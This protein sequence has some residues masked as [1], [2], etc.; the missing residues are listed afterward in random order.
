VTI[1]VLGGTA[2]LIGLLIAIPASRGSDPRGDGAVPEPDELR[3]QFRE[4]VKP[5][6]R[7]YCVSCHDE[8]AASRV[9]LDD[10]EADLTPATIDVWT[11]AKN[12]LDVGTM[13]PK[14]RTERPTREES[15]ALLAWIGA[16]LARYE[17]NHRE[18]GGDTLIRRVNNRAYARMLETL[19]GVPAQ[20][21]G[22]FPKDGEVRGYDT[23]G[24]GLYAT[25]SL[26]DLYLSCAQRTLDIAIPTA[27]AMP[28]AT[29]ATAVLR[30][31]GKA[32]EQVRASLAK[33][34]R[35]LRDDPRT[36]ATRDRCG[37]PFALGRLPVPAPLLRM[38][39]PNLVAEIVT[40][41]YRRPT[42]EA[43]VADG[44][45]WAADPACAAELLPAL[46]EQL[47]LLESFED[48]VSDLQPVSI[49]GNGTLK[50]GSLAPGYYRIRARLCL[51]DPAYPVP[52]CVSAGD[53]VVDQF[54]LYDPPSA[55]TV[56]E[57]TI[58]VGARLD[59]VEVRSPLPYAGDLTRRFGAVRYLVDHAKALYGLTDQRCEEMKLSNWIGANYFVSPTAPGTVA[60]PPA[61]IGI[62]CSEI[63]VS[64]PL[65]QAWPPP[66]ASRIFT[67]GPHAPPSREYAEEI[68]AAFMKRAYAV[69]G[70]DHDE[71]A[72]YVDLIMSHYQTG[73]DFVAAVK[74][75]LAG[76]LASPRFLYLDEERRDHGSQRRP[77]SGS[78]LSRRLA[79][80]LWSDLPDEELVASAAAGA[81]AKDG[82]VLA[83]VRRMLKDPRS[84]A[85]REAFATQWLRIDKLGSIA[86]SNELFPSYDQLL[87]ESAREESVAFFSEILD[88]RLGVETFIDSDFTMLNGRL[89][90]HYGIPGVVGD[91]FRRV[92][93]PAGSHR[94]GVL[95]QASVLM[96][97][98]N[99]MVTSPVRRGVFVMERLLG[100]S[101]GAPPPNVPALD[102]VRTAK[103][104]G[105]PFTHRERLAM[106]AADPSCAR[107]HGKIDPLGVG[108]EGYNALG[109]WSAKATRLLP[110]PDAKTKSRWR[111]Y[112]PDLRGA[113]LDGAPYE[114]PEGLKRR[115]LEHQDQFL[116]CLAENLAIYALGRDLQRSD[117]PILERICATVTADHS[118]LATLVEQVVLSDLFRDK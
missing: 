61:G 99:G 108:L 105:T 31:K 25:S 72:P 67:R 27:E 62:L 59:Q 102:D 58:F 115:L 45:D 33:A 12:V 52:V 89:A 49:H 76:I 71:T 3:Q 90:L 43:V 70:C 112:E 113:M 82:E 77:L 78:E 111:D 29:N 41:R 69:G 23:V 88:Q 17:A 37:I 80:F 44:I 60:I 63:S 56:H 7:K 26:Y 101:P 35:D 57:T 8:D 20:G 79:Y 100:V 114:G 11:R 54:M 81:L 9:R 21:V 51:Q 87:I 64:G 106:H 46:E 95:T 53:R 50:L 4:R 110:E 18:T 96:A 94:G 39:R 14:R 1:V 98:S 42:I 107:C 16:S 68:V 109:A 48:Y 28:K 6:L 73:N 22:D 97:T 47:R 34:I 116:R 118:S 74:F 66:A 30:R 84:R 38:L 10:L 40:A 24:S 75:G 36:F 93:L 86:F 65:Y 2:L 91:E 5:L 83:Q 55:P 85:F 103:E 117:Q 104:D 13:P 92:P 19:L 15:E 32:F